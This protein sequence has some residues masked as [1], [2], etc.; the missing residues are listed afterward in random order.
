VNVTIC[1]TLMVTFHIVRG[2]AVKPQA[3]SH[4][5]A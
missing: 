2:E 5:S 4:P 3:R 1:K